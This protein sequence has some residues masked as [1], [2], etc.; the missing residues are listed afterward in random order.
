M[1][2]K[3]V[4]VSIESTIIEVAGSLYPVNQIS[5]VKVVAVKKSTWEFL[6]G[7]RRYAILLRRKL[8]SA[9]SES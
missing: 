9:S 6:S 2:Q 4:R 1:G 3:V 8:F 5:G 7:G